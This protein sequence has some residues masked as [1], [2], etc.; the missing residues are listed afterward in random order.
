MSLTLQFY[1]TKSNPKQINKTIT[2]VG[3]AINLNPFEDF[4]LEDPFVILDNGTPVGNYAKIDN[5]YFFAEEP[6]LM[7][8]ER[9]MVRFTKDVLMSNKTELMGVNIITEREFMGDSWIVDPLQV[10]TVQKITQ[11]YEMG[12]IG[13]GFVQGGRVILAAI[14]SKDVV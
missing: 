12:D 4:D 10:R 5:D 2:A 7:T 8:G 13:H 14:G 3:A 6:V 11:N 9:K 1:N